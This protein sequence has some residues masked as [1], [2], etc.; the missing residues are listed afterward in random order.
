MFKVGIFVYV[1]QH[2]NPKKDVTLFVDEV[3]T[4]IVVQKKWIHK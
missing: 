3:E 2:D 4:N 1:L